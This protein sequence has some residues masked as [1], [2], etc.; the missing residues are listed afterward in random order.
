MGIRKNCTEF[1]VNPHRSVGSTFLVLDLDG[2]ILSRIPVDL[3][4]KSDPAFSPDGSLIAFRGGPA[5]SIR[6]PAHRESIYIIDEEVNDLQSISE[7]PESDTTA[8]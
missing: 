8:P 2:K 4:S 1:V 7:N 5:L 3:P 6:D